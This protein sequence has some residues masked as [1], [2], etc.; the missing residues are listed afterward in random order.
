MD[1]WLL[2]HAAAHDESPSG[3]DADRALTAEGMARAA[4]VGRGLA[5]LAPTIEVVLSSPYRR[6]RE[7]AEK[8]ARA[9]GVEGVVESSALEPGRAA[10][11]IVR[12]LSGSPWNRVLL[13]GHEPLL[14]TIVGRIVYG[15]EEHA[16]PLRK[17][18]LGRLTW[19]PG[20]TGRLETLLSAKFL[21]RLIA[22]G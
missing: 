10:S 1:L 5:L 2:R 6:A 14:G 9:L 11:E 19:T 20:E 21:E 16:V 17:A 13:V 12:Q 22:A 8:A 4:A 15:D 7:T 18:Q 3:R